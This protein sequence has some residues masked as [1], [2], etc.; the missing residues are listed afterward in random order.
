MHPGLIQVIRAFRSA[1]DLAVITLNE[2][3]GVPLPSSNLEWAKSCHQMELPKLGESIGIQ[4][5]PHGYGVEMKFPSISIDF[6]WG[7]LGEGN[8]FDTWRLWNHCKE[9]KIFLN[10]MTYDLLEIR[11]QKAWE[12]SELVGDRLLYYLPEE[13][14]H[15]RQ[16]SQAG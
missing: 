12:D 6:D 13:R 15:A 7:E 4:I 14:W 3:L 8:G 11:L 5:R 16:T 1:Q 9:N 2:R 10:S